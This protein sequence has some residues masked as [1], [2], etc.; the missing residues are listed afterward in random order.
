MSAF[1][2]LGRGVSDCWLVFITTKR[3]APRLVLGCGYELRASRL[4][5]CKFQ[6]G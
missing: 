6:G 2:S 4:W 1:K 3:G 5:I